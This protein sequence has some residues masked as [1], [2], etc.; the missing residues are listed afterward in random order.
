M[1]SSRKSNLWIPQGKEVKMEDEINKNNF[2]DYII[3]MK[4]KDI[5]YDFIMNIFGEF[6]QSP[7]AHPY[8]LIEIPANTFFY[9]DEKDKEHGNKEKFTTSVGLYLFNLILTDF[10][11]SKFFNGYF[12][13]S[14]NKKG[15]GKIEQTLSY[16]LIEDKI[17]TDDLRRWE[18]TLQWF[19]PFEDVLSPNQT[20]KLVTC[21]K[22]IDKH[23]AELIKKYSKEIE[24][25]DPKVAEDME[26]ELLSFAKEYLGDDPAM[27]TILSKAGGDFENNFKNMYVMKGAIKN[28]DPY[29]QKQYDIVTSSYMDGISAEEYA[30]I[31]G[32]GTYGAYSRGK[33]T[34]DGGYWEKLFVYAF[35]HLKL[36]PKGSD[37]HT[38]RYI[39]VDLTEDNIGDYMYCYTIQG[40]NLV[41]INSENKSK[42]VGK[43]IKLRFASMCEMK[44]GF[45]NKCAGDLVYLLSNN[46]G[47]ILPQIP[48]RLKTICMKSFHNSTVT[49]TEF[50]PYKAFFPFE[51]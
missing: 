42:F 18:D 20:E 36:Y 41:L 6:D 39:T 48:D 30:V 47:M 22:I 32:S 45:C 34:A 23:K 38:K 28:P 25:G 51:D 5:N 43:K 46:I 35:Q 37:C 29:A 13:Q 44:D 27:D 21:T 40:D 8:D 7:I 33:K 50:D 14:I 1:D 19:M 24:A 2:A 11:F 31:A 9:K 12:N 10:N 15:L 26:K 3:N 49:T 4:Y 16:A 17:T